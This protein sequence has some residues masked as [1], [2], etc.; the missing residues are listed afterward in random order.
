MIWFSINKKKWKMIQF[1][2]NVDLK[3]NGGFLKQ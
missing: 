2:K 3:T 1:M